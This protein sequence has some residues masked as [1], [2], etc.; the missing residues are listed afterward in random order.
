MT[1]ETVNFSGEVL[2]I[3]GDSHRYRFDQPLL[4]PR[5]K[6]ALPNFTRLEVF[7]Y[8]FMNWV[9]VRVAQRDGKVTFSASPGV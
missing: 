7:G 3:H 5:T 8:P 6:H 1:Q 2:L 4:D 9:R